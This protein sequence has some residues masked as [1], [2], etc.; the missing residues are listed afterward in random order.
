MERRGKENETEEGQDSQGRVQYDFVR[1]SR[2]F[3]GEQDA[4][5]G[6]EGRLWSS[7]HRT[8]SD[9]PQNPSITQVDDR[10][11]L[12]EMASFVQPCCASCMRG[13]LPGARSSASPPLRCTNYYYGLASEVPSYSN[14]HTASC[15]IP[16]PSRPLLPAFVCHPVSAIDAWIGLNETPLLPS[17]RASSPDRG[18]SASHRQ[19]PTTV[20]PRRLPYALA[21]L[22]NDGSW[23]WA[24]E[25]LIDS[26]HPRWWWSL[27]APGSDTWHSVVISSGQGRFF[28]RCQCREKLGAFVGP[29]VIPLNLASVTAMNDRAR[30]PSPSP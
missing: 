23:L 12:R 2:W 17:S 3:T 10:S 8:T 5:D 28:Y 26:T 15:H 24:T 6:D 1:P 18:S 20:G 29:C 11:V 13:A 22:W 27:L 19:S 16:P 25:L 9:E 14:P 4:V 7:P 21:A 30:G